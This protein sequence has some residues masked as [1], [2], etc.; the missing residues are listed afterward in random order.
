VLVKLVQAVSL[1]REMVCAA[2]RVKEYGIPTAAISG[3]NGLSQRG[4]MVVMNDQA[5]TTAKD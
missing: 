5:A 2:A 4:L 3:T 1:E